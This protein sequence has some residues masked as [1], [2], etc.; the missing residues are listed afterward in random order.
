MITYAEARSKINTRNEAERQ[1]LSDA[2]RFSNHYRA[3]R[4]VPDKR[5]RRDAMRVE[6]RQMLAQVW[7]DN[8]PV[9][10]PVA[11]W[12]FWLVVRSIVWQV[13]LLMWGELDS[14]QYADCAQASGITTNGID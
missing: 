11:V 13:V 6:F 10:N 14:K 12:L 4:G 2:Y 9:G 1:V 5:A 8:R 3:F 7:L